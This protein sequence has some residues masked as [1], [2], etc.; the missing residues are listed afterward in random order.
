[1]AAI[2]THHDNKNTVFPT[3]KDRRLLQPFPLFLDNSAAGTL[4]STQTTLHT[5]VLI[6]LISGIARLDSTRRAAGSTGAARDTF[7]G[8][9]EH[10]S[11]PL[12]IIPKTKPVTPPALY[13]KIA[14]NDKKIKCILQKN[15]LSLS[16]HILPPAHIFNCPQPPA[17]YQPTPYS[18]SI[19]PIFMLY[20]PNNANAAQ[21]KAQTRSQ[22]SAQLAAQITAQIRPHPATTKFIFYQNSCIL[23]LHH[24]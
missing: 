8:N 10:D 9:F 22:T 18:I 2:K 1:M 15:S 4:R 17:F 21:T 6:D 14:R 20:T 23:I 24:L 16:G 12:I 11:F 19:I 5:F 7:F 3:E 13:N